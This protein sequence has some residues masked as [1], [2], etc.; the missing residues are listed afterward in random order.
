MADQL[1]ERDRLR[2]DA[3]QLRAV[4]ERIG[5][6]LKAR[7]DAVAIAVHELRNPLTSVR[8]YATLMSRNLSAVQS[9][10]HDVEQLIGELLGPSPTE[11]GETS[12]VVHEVRE[13]IARTRAST[14][15]FID[16]VPP[17]SPPIAAID[18]LRLAQV[19]DN[20]LRNAAKYS[21]A[22]SRI[23]VEIA[24]DE[25]EVVVAVRDQGTGIESADLEH[26]FTQ[27]FRSPRHAHL[28][29]EGLGLAVCR[30]IVET[31]GGRIWAASAGPDRGSTFYVAL[32]RVPVLTGI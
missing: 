16:L 32:H 9:Q 30:R 7:E 14:G 23:A 31:A 3:G 8:G 24:T 12:D 28:A 10:L 27:G 18:R 13:A 26:I 25:R 2:A 29:G 17:E 5:V 11:T 19:L 20:L 15:R 21:P 6:E 22:G 1:R 4:A